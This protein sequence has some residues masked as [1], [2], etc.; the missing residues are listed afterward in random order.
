MTFGQTLRQLL[1][2]SGVKSAA[3]ASRLGYDT[4]YISR[5]IS[6][7]KLPSLKNNS[8]LFSQIAEGI[9]EESDS[10]AREELRQT[11]CRDGSDAELEQAIESAL[12]L[13][14]TCS[15][16]AVHQQAAMSRNAIC[17]P[18]GM[19]KDG[20]DIYINAMTQ[21][22][23]ETGDREIPCITATPLKPYNNQNEAFWGAIL[24][25]PQIFGKL[26]IILHQLIDSS[27]FSANV[28]SY[29][30]AICTFA[31]YHEGIKYEFYE[32]NSV[33]DIHSVQFIYIADKLSYQIIKNP[34][35]GI[36]E[37]VICNDAAALSNR[38]FSIC[39][40][41]QLLP[42]LLSYQ[43]C[44][45][46]YFRHFLYDYVMGGELRYLLNIMQ[47]FFIT[48]ELAD[49]FIEQ[50]VADGKEE[51]RSFY[52]YF[53][54]LCSKAAKEVI[55]FRSALLE[56]I[57]SG[58]ILFCGRLLKV[59]REHRINHMKQLLENMKQ[60]HCRLT[61]LSDANPLLNYNDME[62]SL[63]L[64]KSNGFME[65]SDNSGHYIVQISSRL[66]TECFQQFFCHLQ[67]LGG[68]YVMKGKEAC[69]F[70]E[71]GLGLI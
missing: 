33:A 67:E 50:Y 60:E 8:R 17:I 2:I 12:S 44:S 31:H 56:Y 54:S 11:F 30:A 51:I 46:K 4:S 61:I 66:A 28:D 59:D 35:T 36:V 20:Y 27:D 23:Q 71:K 57:Y 34:F 43:N 22:A 3:L 42:K 41:L 45:S 21:Y 10:S 68:S 52:M 62:M 70:I 64:N 40:Q 9:L 53:N 19:Y 1:T 37:T 16:P 65:P 38:W 32:Y 5:W 6:D 13:A 18:D 26:H 15:R 69:D 14:F 25:S 39:K 7:I 63:Y 48:D 55:I 24:S 49:E 47:P 58:T 29:C